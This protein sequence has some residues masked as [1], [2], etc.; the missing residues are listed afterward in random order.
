MRHLLIALLTVA[1]TAW[2][3]SIDRKALLLRNNPIV[4]QIDSLS[5]LSVGNGDFAFTVD[6]TGLQT[7]PEH[8][9][10]GVP[11]G[12]MSSWG[13]HYFPNTKNVHFNEV[14][15]ERDFG[16]GHKELYAGQQKAHRAKE[17]ADYFRANP[18][19][20]HLGNVGLYGISIE[21]ISDIR[22][23]LILEKGEIISHY[24]LHGKEV[25]VRTVCHPASSKVAVSI[26]SAKPLPIVVR[27]PYPTGGHSDDACDWNKGSAF[28]HTAFSATKQAVQMTHFFPKEEY[29]TEFNTTETYDASYHLGI[30]A[31]HAISAKR[32]DDNTVLIT[33]RK[34]SI[35]YVLEWDAD[36]TATT[37][38]SPYASIGKE[39]SASWH[40]YWYDGAAVDFSGCTDPRARELERRVVLSQYLLAVNS[41]GATPPQE[42]GLTY[43]SWFGKFH[44]EM[45]WWH[46][47]QFALWGHPEK[48]LRTLRW[49]NTP[50]VLNTARLIAER[51]G[52]KGVRWMKMTD[53]SGLEAPSKVGSYLIW[54]QPHYIHLAELL[55][56]VSKPQEA[57]AIVDEFAE[58]INLTA[59]FMADFASY[60]AE[61]NRYLLKGYIPAQETLRA[62]E[63]V[64]S[65][66][67]LSQWHLV[68]GIAQQWRSLTNKPTVPLW[69]DIINRL[70]PLASKDS[71][72]LAAETAPQTYTDPR[73]TRDHMAV[74]GA[75][76][77]FPLWQ[78]IDK[79]IM[80]NTL[81]W[82]QQNWQWD[83]TWGWDHPM[84]AMCA[85]RLG[86]PNEAVNA[87]LAPHRTNTYLVSG[88]NYQDQ[89][90][91]LYLPG[92]GALLQAVALMC[93]GW[94]GCTTATPGFPHDGT[95]NVKWEGLFPLP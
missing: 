12:T 20:L 77:I 36:T 78:G 4:T 81:R 18:H 29:A 1:T 71:L 2:A 68:M 5:S 10:N 39:A 64:N 79:G 62:S 86:K 25:T 53:E 44:L 24:R 3:Q 55:R 37:A 63:V 87:L 23:E 28:H 41:G 7:F 69:D 94:D 21:D 95:W 26:T 84:T 6:A 89:R 88:H 59:Q 70:S 75:L 85:A 31:S 58:N 14:L 35:E 90:L 92:N 38:F 61:Y 15:E 48:L 17:A 52:F 67:E 93:A 66:F 54:Q 45:I 43:N 22:Q 16:H 73:F 91:R 32:I 8:Y 47:A 82:V 49:Y 40:H 42:T 65:P 51:Q 46:Q 80:L 13:W 60:D 56:R 83:H 74:L 11:L 72:Y 33:P 9:S 27:M 76:G 34:G 57:R 30:A 50:V 19:R